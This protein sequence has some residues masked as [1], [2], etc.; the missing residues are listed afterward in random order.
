[1][2]K[3]PRPLEQYFTKFTENFL[4]YVQELSPKEL[5]ESGLTIFL[6]YISYARFKNPTMIW[7]GPLAL[8]LIETPSQGEG[9]TIGALGVNIPLPTPQ[10]I[11]L[12]MLA[13]LGVLNFLDGIQM[14]PFDETLTGQATKDYLSSQGISLEDYLNFRSK[15][16]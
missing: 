1:M 15:A 5:V 12:A 3:K 2:G 11:G 7:Y 9:T 4:S 16:T 10:Q 6:A 8:K 13:I 14:K